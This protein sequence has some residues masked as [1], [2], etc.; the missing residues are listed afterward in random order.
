M[1]VRLFEKVVHNIKIN[2]IGKIFEKEKT[3]KPA[4]FDGVTKEYPR[5]EEKR[6]R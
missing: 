4:G 2:D 1:I 3:G 5:F 6:V